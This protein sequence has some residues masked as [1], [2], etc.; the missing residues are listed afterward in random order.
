MKSSMDFLYNFYYNLSSNDET[1]I[2]VS[3]YFLLIIYFGELFTIIVVKNIDKE[4]FLNI[5]NSVPKTFLSKFKCERNK[6]R[7]MTKENKIDVRKVALKRGFCSQ[8]IK[9]RR[10]MVNMR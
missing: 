7:L 3:Y 2:G 1:E 6:L 9:I 4:Y 10:A 5:N 8:I